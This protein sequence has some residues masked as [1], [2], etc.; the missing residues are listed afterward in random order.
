MLGAC[1]VHPE[2]SNVIPLCP[3]IIHN[4]DGSEK[5]DCERNAAKRFLENFKREHSHLKVVI[6]TDGIS[7]NA[8]YIR[9]LEENQMSYIL[10]AKPGDRKFLFDF[11][12]SSEET[13][14]H[15]ILDD[16]GF[17]H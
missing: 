13:T 11:I 7:S 6:V 8:S 4:G 16:K 9:L 17:L 2:K 14:Y 3:E 15:E 1:I 10:G 5:N 12:E